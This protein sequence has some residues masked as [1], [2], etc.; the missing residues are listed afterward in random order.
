MKVNFKM[1]EK[2]NAITETLKTARCQNKAFDNRHMILP[3]DR[4]KIAPNTET[5][6]LVLT[7]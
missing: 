5:L 3:H 7:Y 4:L 1:K 2:K 6:Y